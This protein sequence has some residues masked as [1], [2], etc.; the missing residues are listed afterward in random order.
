MKLNIDNKPGGMVFNKD[1]EV[2]VQQNNLLDF[3]TVMTFKDGEVVKHAVPERK[4]EKFFLKEDDTSLHVYLKRHYPQSFPKV[5]FQ[6]MKLS[7]SET[8]FDEFHYI[9]DFHTA[10]LPTMIP[11]AAGV[12][13]VGLFGKESFL[14]TKAIEGCVRLDHFFS[15][16]SRV[17]RRQRRA[18]L[19][20]VALMVKKMH[21]AGFN[22]RD[23]YLCHILF[24]N[25]KELFFVDLHRVEKRK[26]VPDR[27]KVKD[28]AALHY[29]APKETISRSD[30]LFFLKTYF[31]AERLSGEERRFAIKVLK[32]T[33]KMIEHNENKAQ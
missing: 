7:R 18:V 24:D 21:D 22:H 10:D 17:S 1:F 29:S 6:A 3:D 20:K 4:T 8:A 25:V 2:F 9:V 30:R 23:L 11:I 5:L 15:P 13:R 19:K 27:W 33:K 12:R 26:Q 31:E 16:G 32:K 14:V 28:I